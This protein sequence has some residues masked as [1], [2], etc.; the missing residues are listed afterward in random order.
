[1]RFLRATSRYSPLDIVQAF[2]KNSGVVEN[3]SNK[4]NEDGASDPQSPP[5]YP[6]DATPPPY[7]GE[8]GPSPVDSS[9]SAP[10]GGS[11]N[12][13]N[14]GGFSGGASGAGV[15]LSDGDSKMWAMLAH[16]LGIVGAFVAPL[17][18]M[19]VFSPRSAFVEKHAK[20]ALNFQIIVTIAF[21]VSMVLSGACI[22]FFMFIGVFIA[23]LVLCI[24]AGLEANKGNDYKYPFNYAFVK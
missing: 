13:G 10:T 12:S 5:P 4:P 24:I 15:P 11:T 23:N 18:I 14:G 6:S 2:R 1:M 17:V 9:P 16:L 19:L 22:G 20:E 21:L 7:P 8:P 3:D